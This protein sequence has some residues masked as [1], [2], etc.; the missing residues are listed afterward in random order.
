MIEKMVYAGSFDP[1]TKGH[2]DLIRRGAQMCDTLLVCVGNNVNK[3]YMFTAM[4]RANMIRQS[5]NLLNINNCLVDINETV[6]LA[7][8]ASVYGVTHILRGIRNGN[9]LVAE[10]DMHEI[11][12]LFNPTLDTVLLMASPQHQHI[13]S[14]AVREI[15]KFPN[16]EN[17]MKQLVTLPVHDALMF[18]QH[19]KTGTTS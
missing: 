12:Q 2:M 16:W 10:K 15:Y 18:R 4:E 9:D 13:S 3:Q 14:S 19:G 8:Y 11:N 17:T 6:T 5:I 7:D 1:V